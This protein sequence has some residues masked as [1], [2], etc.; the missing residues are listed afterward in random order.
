MLSQQ[1]VRI[2]YLGSLHRRPGV[3]WSLSLV[4]CRKKQKSLVIALTAYFVHDVGC[5]TQKNMKILTRSKMRSVKPHAWYSIGPSNAIKLALSCQ[6]V[7]TGILTC[8]SS[9]SLVHSRLKYWINVAARLQTLSQCTGLLRVSFWFAMGNSFSHLL[10]F[11]I[12]FSQVI[13]Q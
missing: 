6:K 10:L 12:F 4:D 2:G 3:L 11:V 8:S 1:A 7:D 9:S 5:G 13:F